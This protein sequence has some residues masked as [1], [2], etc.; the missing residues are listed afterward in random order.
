MV[1][2][3]FIPSVALAAVGIFGFMYAIIIKKIRNKLKINSKNI[4]H[5][6]TQTIR[7][8]Q[9]GLGGI[10]DILID[11]TQ[12]TF[13]AIYRRSDLVLRH[14]QGSNQFMSQSP[15]FGMEAMGMVLIAGL[16]Y[17][18]TQQT[19]GIIKVIPVLAAL[20]LGLQR[21]LPALQQAYQAWSTI[22]GAHASLQDTLELLDQPLPNSSIQS[23][24]V[25]VT[26]GCDISLRQLSF[27]YSPD[28]PY[29]L[30][31]IDLTIKKGSRIGFIGTTGSG[32]STLLDIIMGLL[33]PTGGTI[34]VDGHSIT[35]GNLQSWRK[36]IAHVPQSV[37]LT[38]GNV[39]AN[40]AF[41][42]PPEQIDPMRLRQA[43][44]QAQIADA[45]ESWPLQ[46][47]SVVGE[48]GVQLSGGQR[49]RIGIARALYKNA[50]LI[51]FDEATSALDSKTEVAAMEAIELLSKDITIL[52]VAHRL[53]TL[54]KCDEI[55]EIVNG[56]LI[57][58]K[59]LSNE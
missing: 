26:F 56:N 2:A 39:E 8:L 11:G 5:E 24:V 55:L 16:A 1:L 50:N 3:L 57:Y 36:H 20:A 42:V 40:I 10:R 32:K 12:E 22:Q 46:Y 4:A 13:C 15:R 9:E 25:P 7:Y 14:A 54:D 34:N 52:I 37:F 45:I 18:L 58:R 48:R 35:P 31:N 49:Q 27:Q 38:D 17:V 29:V 44:S 59:Q 28:K 47:K 21:L 6:S 23:S 30:K 19:N 43:A 53:S 41:G 51:I 33:Q